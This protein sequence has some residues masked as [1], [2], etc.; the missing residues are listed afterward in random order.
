MGEPKR[1]ALT[2][3]S[4]GIGRALF[5]YYAARPEA[6]TVAGIARSDEAIHELQAQYPNA[7]AQTCDVR[8]RLAVE[9][10]SQTALE[11]LQ[12]LDLL[13]LNSGATL[14][15]QR[16]DRASLSEIEDILNTNYAGMVRVL[17]S[18]LPTLRSSSGVIA[19]V[20]LPA[21]GFPPAGLV[22]YA[23]SKQGAGLLLDLLEAESPKSLTRVNVFPG[24]V[25]TALTRSIMGKKA[26]IY[27]SAEKWV[28]RA[29]VRIAELGPE[30]N[31]KHI[32]LMRG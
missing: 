10:W 14:K 5:E 11:R 32:S 12:G 26:D 7:D 29:A 16:F 20:T 23:L 17:H 8:S 31:G 25:D 3:I 6:Y 9:K 27:P 2:G 21:S 22:P 4:R 19:H 18:F 30:D 15:P 1:I 28:E 24:V 13:I